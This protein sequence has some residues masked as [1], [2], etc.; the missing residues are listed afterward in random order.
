MTNISD[1]ADADTYEGITT[2]KISTNS[3]E[4][5]PNKFKF[6]TGTKLQPWPASEYRNSFRFEKSGQAIGYIYYATGIGKERWIYETNTF[7]NALTSL[8]LVLATA[9]L[10]LATII[11]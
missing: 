3:A 11:F 1:V 5:D 8:S 7:N 4:T 6:W 10:F 9:G 2:F